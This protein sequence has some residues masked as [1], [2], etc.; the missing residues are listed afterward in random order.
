MN[1]SVPSR[2]NSRLTTAENVRQ[3]PTSIIKTD[4]RQRAKRD[5][6][7]P[8][9]GATMTRTYKARIKPIRSRRE[10]VRYQDSLFYR[11]DLTRPRPVL[12]SRTNLQW[13]Q[14][15]RYMGQ[16]CISRSH[17]W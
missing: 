3:T 7:T 6:K 16:P 4:S 1:I 12:V 2:G 9:A 5:L 14:Q 15:G 11:A 8:Q 13:K 10:A 17:V